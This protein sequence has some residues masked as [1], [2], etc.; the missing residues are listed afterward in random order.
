MSIAYGTWY[1]AYLHDRFGSTDAAL[2]AYNAG[3]GNL[4]R[5]QREARARGR[6]FRIPEDVP[7][8]ETRAFVRQVK[9]ARSRYAG[10][11]EEVLGGS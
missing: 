6:E 3:E 5:W 4:D 2:V 9:E 8:A 1:L 7:L 11:Y 10:A